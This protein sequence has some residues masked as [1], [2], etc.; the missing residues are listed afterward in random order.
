MD[1]DEPRRLPG[2]GTRG[3]GRVRLLLFAALLAFAAHATLR[4][5]GGVLDNYFYE[6][7][8]AGHLIGDGYAF[9]HFRPVQWVFLRLLFRA[10]GGQP[11]GY[12]LA[13]L[14]LHAASALCVGWLAL[15]LSARPWAAAAATLV[16]AQLFAPHEAVLWISANGGL[17]VVLFLLLF[18]LAWDA[19]LA[20]R[21][22]WHYA[23]A[24]LAALLAMGSKEDCV[25]LAPLALGLDRLRSGHQVQRGFLRRYAPLALLAA[26]YLALALRSSLLEAREYGAHGALLGKLVKNFAWL[27]W[28]RPLEQHDLPAWGLLAGA[29]LLLGL[30]WLAWRERRRVPVLGL[31]LVLAV[32]G[33]LVVLPIAPEGF[34]TQRLSYPSA[35]GVALLAAGLVQ[36]GDVRSCGLG[37]GLRLGLGGA[38]ILLAVCWSTLQVDAIRDVEQRRFERSG[39][40]YRGALEST[41]RSA[42][43]A[44]LAAGSGRALVVAPFVNPQQYGRGLFVLMGVPRECLDLRYPPQEEVLAELPAWLASPGTLVFA[45]TPEGPLVRLESEADVPAE[46]WQRQAAERERVGRGATLPVLELAHP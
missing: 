11:R 13:G 36:L 24:L 17:L 18:A 2:D 7:D 20:S 29:A 12:Y 27:L 35:I 14:V 40:R 46:D 8:D 1:P 6:S 41:R 33:L 34:A 39:A 26:L 19:Y 28:P 32:A 43:E 3:P 21:R 23:L 44:L 5:Y 25:L 31:G 37:R 16:F 10:F 30:G 4:A 45:G 9:G 22:R 42:W 15:R 38:A